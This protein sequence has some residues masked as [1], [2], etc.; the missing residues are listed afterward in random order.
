MAE[1][2]LNI[3]D[4]KTGKCYQRTIG[5]PSIESFIGLKMGEKING[6]S[7]DLKGYEFEITGGSDSAG[8]PMRKGVQTARKRVLAERGA[9]F[10][11]VIKGLKRRKT[12]CGETITNKMIQINLKI[13]KHGEQKLGG[14]EKKAEESSKEEKKE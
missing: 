7:F 5:E 10:R 1:F 8:F 9:G 13:L 3:A 6:D 11:K 2:K 4:P 14:A 12:V